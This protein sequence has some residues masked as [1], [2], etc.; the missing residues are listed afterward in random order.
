MSNQFEPLDSE[1]VVSRKEDS[2]LVLN[3]RMF[4]ATDFLESAQQK[5]GIHTV[6]SRELWLE[7]GV[8]CEVLE[9]GSPSWVQGKLRV[10]VILE[11]C[12]DELQ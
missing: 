5:L 2:Y 7:S 6:E 10:R 1:A 12:P 9:L 11:F 8:E 4:K 3:E